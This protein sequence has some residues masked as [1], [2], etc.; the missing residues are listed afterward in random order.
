MCTLSTFSSPPF[1]DAL[2]SLASHATGKCQMIK[3][4]K[5]L[6]LQPGYENSFLVRSAEYITVLF[7]ELLVTPF[8]R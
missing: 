2:S 3:E 8:L 5:K 7:S 1:C 4:V 6:K